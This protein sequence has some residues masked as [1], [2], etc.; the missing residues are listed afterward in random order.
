MLERLRTLIYASRFESY[1][2][3]VESQDVSE[4]LKDSGD[5]LEA[6]LKD[7]TSEQWQHR[8]ASGKWT[9][10][11]VVFHIVQTE[12][13]FNFRAMTI[14]CDSGGVDLPGFDEDE[15][16]RNMSLTP[17]HES[18]LLPLFRATRQ[19]TISLSK[20]L[21]PEQMAKRGMASGHE[22]QVEALFYIVSGHTRHHL[23]VL[24]DRYLKLA[25]KTHT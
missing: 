13:I 23:G 6:F 18:L 14:A 11:E 22:V 12:L 1:L 15:F 16:V 5:C 21:G 24:R 10:A 19:Q 2:T 20:M 8:Y 7:A 4:E 9:M 17:A 3:L 25:G